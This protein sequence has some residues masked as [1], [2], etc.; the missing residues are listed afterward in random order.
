M[1]KTRFLLKLCCTGFIMLQ[2]LGL[3]GQT[4]MELMKHWAPQ[5]YQDTRN[6]KVTIIPWI[7]TH[8][9]Y[10][11]QDFILKVNYDGNWYAGDQRENSRKHGNSCG[12]GFAGHAY[13]SMVETNTHYFFGYGYYHSMDDAVIEA[14]RH[15]NDYEDVYICVHKDGS[16]Y[17]Q[18]QAMVTNR[19]GSRLKYSISDTVNDLNFTG[20][21]VQIYI[22]SNGDVTGSCGTQAHG[23]GIESYRPGNHCT[24]SDAII[25]N[26]ADEG[27]VPAYCGGG[28]FAHSYNYSLIDIDE[29]WNRRLDWN[30]HP[31]GSYGGFGG[32]GNEDNGGNPPWRNGYF[33][34]PAPKFLTD[35]G[36][37][38]DGVSYSTNY[39]HNPYYEN[40]SDGTVNPFIGLGGNWNR[41][42]I[43]SPDKAGYSWIW[44]DM[45]TIS[46]AGTDIWGTSDQ[47]HY[48]YQPLSGDGEIVT[49]L[50]TIQENINSWSKAGVM[51]RE[52][53]NAN[54]KFSM[55]VG[56]SHNGVS[57]QNRTSTGGSAIHNTNSGLKAAPGWLKLKRSG[58]RFTAYYSADGSSWASIGSQNISMSSS[59]YVGLAV[60]SHEANY[61]CSATFT[62]V[63]VTQNTIKSGMLT[64]VQKLNIPTELNIKAY[65]KESTL[66]LTLSSE[67]LQNSRL[68]IYDT[69]GR[70][71]LDTKVK[72]MYNEYPMAHKGIYIVKVL[73]NEGL[74]HQSKV[75]IR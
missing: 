3:L 66:I 63:S 23:H 28:A 31:F 51:I 74:Q 13:A 25:Y 18:F 57:F 71:V 4:K 68:M 69:M 8:Q 53:L 43:G 46:G 27:Q 65:S 35:F 12:A 26:V 55:L 64:N 75:L 39:L 9:F 10:E 54:S 21:H 60:T 6:D 11:A 73:S 30:N 20:D 70:K 72:S 37:L 56:T 14:D 67:T 42:D 1:K 5:V 50:Y 2:C 29:L 44:K 40:T 38:D 17:G 19:H 36:W 7:W 61:L 45:F 58:N 49:R 41:T 52:S 59:V 22:S 32:D 15:E 62:N 16:T 48:V 47:F 34:N 33:D 24:G